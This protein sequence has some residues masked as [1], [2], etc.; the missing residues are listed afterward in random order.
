MLKL[1][2]Y[3]IEINSYWNTFEQSAYTFTLFCKINQLLVLYLANISAILNPLQIVS[4]P[5]MTPP[6]F[7]LTLKIWMED[8]HGIIVVS[9]S[10]SDMKDVLMWNV[11]WYW[12]TSCW[13]YKMNWNISLFCNIAA[14]FAYIP[15]IKVFMLECIRSISN[16]TIISASC[17]TS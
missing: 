17:Y 9:R 3:N 16:I 14:I 7:D 12:H 11:L 13:L 5:E 8:V 15:L 4:H 10:S 6:V 2:D 1:T